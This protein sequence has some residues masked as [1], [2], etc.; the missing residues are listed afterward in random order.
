VFEFFLTIWD[1]ALPVLGNDELCETADI[2]NESQSG[3]FAS[4]CL[5]ISMVRS[6]MA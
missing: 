5:R 6:M 4:Y 1:I 2:A 3:F